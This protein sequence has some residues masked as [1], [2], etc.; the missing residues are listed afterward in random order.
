MFLKKSYLI[1]N[2]FI[3]LFESAPNMSS[4]LV[5]FWRNYT[6]ESKGHLFAKF[7]T[8]VDDESKLSSIAHFRDS[9]NMHSVQLTALV[10]LFPDFSDY[11]SHEETLPIVM[12]CYVE[13]IV[14]RW[15]VSFN[16][17]KGT[18]RGLSG[19]DYKFSDIW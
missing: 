1:R 9:L 3:S 16:M 4:L 8:P 13:A 12:K 17:E 14:L 2:A 6:S 11:F 15:V 10:K 5:Q 7:Q 18:L 19:L